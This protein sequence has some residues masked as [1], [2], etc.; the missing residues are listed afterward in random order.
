MKIR[1]PVIVQGEEVWACHAVHHNNDSENL[2]ETWD[3]LSG[4]VLSI[5]YWIE[6]DLPMPQPREVKIKTSLKDDGG[7]INL[8]AVEVT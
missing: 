4:A 5:V 6:I 8:V 3:V 1:L 2:N 7:D